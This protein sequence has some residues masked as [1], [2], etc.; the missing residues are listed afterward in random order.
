[1]NGTDA[2]PEPEVGPAAPAPAARKP[3][4]V[5]LQVFL[6]L[7]ILGCGMVIGSGGTLLVGRRILNPPSRQPAQIGRV[8]SR[9]LTRRLNLTPPQ[10]RQVRDL[11]RQHMERVNEIRQNGRRDAEQELDA[12]RE[13]VAKV[14]TPQ[15][16][17]AW[18]R[19]F[20][21]LR[22]WAPP[23]PPP[24]TRRPGEWRPGPRPGPG[25]GASPPGRP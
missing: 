14:L 12:M 19:E 24:G 4:R 6:G 5:W 9:H 21:R 8:I 15:Q 25:P 22:R 2:V 7:A 20:E 1:M 16:A 11:V 23:P 3:S 17:E 13:D 18:R 10:Q